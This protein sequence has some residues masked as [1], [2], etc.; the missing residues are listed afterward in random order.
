MGLRTRVSVRGW[1]LPGGLGADKGSNVLIH[2]GVLM[3][4]K[5]EG[6]MV[7]GGMLLVVPEPTTRTK[8]DT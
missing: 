2:V 5:S 1:E 8:M 6:C 7:D 3:E 4:R